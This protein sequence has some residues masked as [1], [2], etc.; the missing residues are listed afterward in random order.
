M[1]CQTMCANIIKGQQKQLHRNCGKGQSK[2]TVI[3][4]ITKNL[5]KWWA[6]IVDHND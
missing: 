3:K 4:T 2:L 6:L 5:N 1:L